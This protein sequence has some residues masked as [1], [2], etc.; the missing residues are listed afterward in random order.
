[1]TSSVSYEASERVRSG[2]K[3][4]GHHERVK[5]YSM[6]VPLGAGRSTVAFRNGLEGKKCI[7][8]QRRLASKTKSTKWVII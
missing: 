6:F 3:W 7:N 1:M 4:Q 5:V 2:S 8:E